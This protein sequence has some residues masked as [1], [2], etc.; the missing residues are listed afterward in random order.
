MRKS[1]SGRPLRG[2]AADPAKRGRGP[3]KGAPNAGRPPNEF[4]EHMRALV[5]RA[6]V[7]KALEAVLKSPT[8]P[9]FMAAYKMACEFGY[10]RAVQAVEHAGHG[11]GPMELRIVHEVIDPSEA[12]GDDA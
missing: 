12:D 1:A 7:T 5:S 8:H 3:K 11:G 9:H 2:A 10:G 6:D 4:R